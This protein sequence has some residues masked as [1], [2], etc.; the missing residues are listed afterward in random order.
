MRNAHP[1]RSHILHRS[2]DVQGFLDASGNAAG[3]GMTETY[4][5]NQGQH[6]WT[7]KRFHGVQAETEPTDTNP[8]EVE[9]EHHEP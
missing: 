1:A 6:L 2:L 8:A 4:Q 9:K 3:V 5:D 7:I